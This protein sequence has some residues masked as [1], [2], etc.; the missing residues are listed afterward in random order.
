[1][2][3]NVR[4]GGRIAY[5]SVHAGGLIHMLTLVVVGSVAGVWKAGII[6]SVLDGPVPVGVGGR[7][8]I[9]SRRHTQKY[10]RSGTGYECL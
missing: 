7:L 3:S 8:H 4:R 5:V 9:A 2:L 10:M 6:Q 1:M